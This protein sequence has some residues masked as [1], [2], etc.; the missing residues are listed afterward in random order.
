PKEK[1]DE[2]KF[3]IG[4]TPYKV[5]NI[6]FHLRHLENYFI[7]GLDDNQNHGDKGDYLHSFNDL[8][9]SLSSSLNGNNGIKTK[10]NEL[11]QR[12]TSF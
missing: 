5:D 8:I 1:L 11:K 6:G 4:Y 2:A 9:S 12:V 10:K 7:N 3:N